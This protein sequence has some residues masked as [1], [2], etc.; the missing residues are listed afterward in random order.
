MPKFDLTDDEVNLVMHGLKRVQ[1]DASGVMR[2]I[3]AQVLQKPSESRTIP[4]A[5]GAQA[6]PT[7][8]GG[9]KVEEVKSAGA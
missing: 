4:A 8:A 7:T 2:N 1:D 6:S 9:M 5:P 3:T